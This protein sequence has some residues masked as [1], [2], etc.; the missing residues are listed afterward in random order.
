[1]TV[2]EL[3][4]ILESAPDNMEVIMKIH[5]WDREFDCPYDY[6]DRIAKGQIEEKD[7][8]IC[9]DEEYL[10]KVTKQV[11]MLESFYPPEAEDL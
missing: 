10:G 3:K 9:S 2:K 11:F 7:F 8:Y 5:D 6:D 1:M 4:T